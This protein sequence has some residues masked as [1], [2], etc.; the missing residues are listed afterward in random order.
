MKNMKQKKLPFIK[1]HSKNFYL[2]N[3][4]KKLSLVYFIISAIAYVDWHKDRREMFV[5]S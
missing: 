3:Q 1:L 2:A 5:V 4:K